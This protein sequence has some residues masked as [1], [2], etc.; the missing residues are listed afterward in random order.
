MEVRT[1]KPVYAQGYKSSRMVQGGA[2]LL[3][4]EKKI[5]KGE[6]PGF[7]PPLAPMASL[8]LTSSY[9]CPFITR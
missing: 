4:K 1:E 2:H 8:L 6:S 5:K 9:F 3:L 7:L